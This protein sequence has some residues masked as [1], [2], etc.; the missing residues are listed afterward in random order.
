MSD[1]DYEV[2]LKTTQRN[3]PCPCGSG[4]KYKKCHLVEDEGTR[5][6]TLKALE[7][8]AMAKAKA[9][10]DSEGEG[11]TRGADESTRLP[12]RQKKQ[13]GSKGLAADGRPKNIPRRGA[14]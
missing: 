8:E 9:S 2:R 1:S 11:D 13:R 6:A 5:T 7:E 4:K 14:V 12:K 3:D 10:T